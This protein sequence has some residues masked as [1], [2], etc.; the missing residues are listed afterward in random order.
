[1]VVNATFRPLYP[2][3]RETVLVVQEAGWAPEPVWTGTENLAPTGIR[4]RS[5]Q[6][7]ASRYTG[8]A[9]TAPKINILISGKLRYP[10]TPF[11]RRYQIK[12]I[13]MYTVFCCGVP[14]VAIL[15]TKETENG[16]QVTG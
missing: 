8:Y 7:I 12:H 10:A 4:S 9:T 6:P 3:E 1:M 13:L 2:L 11:P 5:V 15:Q 14:Q 16:P